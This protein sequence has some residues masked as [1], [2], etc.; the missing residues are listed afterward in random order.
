MELRVPITFWS[1]ASAL[2]S[3]PPKPDPTVQDPSS[4]PLHE[5]F[6]FPLGIRFGLREPE[7]V[8]TECTL[9]D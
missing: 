6:G 8:V 3:T 5:D 7:T 2:L 4:P 9:T 1:V